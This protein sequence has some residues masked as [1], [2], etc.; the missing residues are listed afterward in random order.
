MATFFAFCIIINRIHKVGEMNKTYLLLV[1]MAF[2]SCGKGKEV[3]FF[4]AT[5]L[6]LNKL[7][8][9]KDMEV[10]PNL[11]VDKTIINNDYPVEIALY[12][13][14]KFFYNLP[15]LGSG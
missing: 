5:E 4:P 14:N 10:N 15:N 9:E 12:Q 2:L 11:S 13:N 3:K 7:V 1:S 8:N 6:E